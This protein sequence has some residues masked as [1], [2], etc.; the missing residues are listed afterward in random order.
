[1]NIFR[2]R[3]NQSSTSNSGYH[4][5]LLPIKDVAMVEDIKYTEVDRELRTFVTEV[6]QS[7][8]QI[9]TDH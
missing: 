8:W 4:Q 7:K 1:M 5:A 9:V 2:L 3:R 6:S